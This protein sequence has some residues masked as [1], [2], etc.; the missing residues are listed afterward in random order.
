[1]IMELISSVIINEIADLSRHGKIGFVA[2]QLFDGPV[3]ADEFFHVLVSLKS[4]NLKTAHYRH[5]LV[6]FLVNSSRHS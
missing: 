2:Q 1:M 6:F 4:C 5:A 3:K